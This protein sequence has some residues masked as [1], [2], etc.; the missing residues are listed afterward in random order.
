MFV[1]YY[2]TYVTSEQFAPRAFEGSSGT[3]SDFFGGFGSILG[4]TPPEYCL[5]M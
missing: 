2:A 3:S 4:V 1:I 5:K